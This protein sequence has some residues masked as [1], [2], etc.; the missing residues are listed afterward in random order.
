MS[1]LGPSWPSCILP[2]L[3]QSGIL[4]WV[5]LPPIPFPP[6]FFLSDLAS[7]SKFTYLESSQLELQGYPHP[8]TPPPP[9]SPNFFI[10][11][12]FGPLFTASASPGQ[13]PYGEGMLLSCWRILPGLWC[14]CFFSSPEHE[15]LMVSYCD[16]SLSVVPALSTFCF[17][18]LLLQNG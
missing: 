13:R 3:T 2:H 17:K 18:G 9:P 1:D 16:Q 7:L 4:F 11:F 5:S 14:S 15:V 6:I 12:S 10:R 8:P